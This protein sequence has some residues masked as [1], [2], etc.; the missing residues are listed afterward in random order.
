MIHDIE[1]SRAIDNSIKEA[2]IGVASFEPFNPESLKRKFGLPVCL[3]NIG[4]TCY[5]NSLIQT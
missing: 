2:G 3:K 5:F 4:N 1:M